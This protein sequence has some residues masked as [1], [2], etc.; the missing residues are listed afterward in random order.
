MVGVKGI[1]YG[2]NHGL[3]W[4]VEG[5]FTR[6]P[7]AIPYLSQASLAMKELKGLLSSVEGVRLED[8][9][10]AIGIHYRHCAEPERARRA[11]LD[12]ISRAASAANFAVQEGRKV[13]ELRP[14]LSINKGT[15]LER[16]VREHQLKGAI[17]LGDDSTDLDAFHALHRWMGGEGNKGAAIA[18]VSAESP[19]GLQDQADYTLEGVDEVESFLEWLGQRMGATAN[20]T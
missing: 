14:P 10:I 9:G 20:Q 16:L 2:G 12:A 4:E 13:V 15:A 17:Y 6:H 19:A 5:Q 8:K 18:V 1:I 11:I 3:E 7:K